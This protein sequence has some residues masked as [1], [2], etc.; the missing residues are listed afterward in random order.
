MTP[1]QTLHTHDAGGDLYVLVFRRT[2]HQNTTK[3]LVHKFSTGEIKTADGR[4][5]V[6][7]ISKGVYE[8]EPDPTGMFTD[9]SFTNQS[10]RVTSDDPN[11]P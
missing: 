1:I 5:N 9:P 7:Y 4:R 6:R 2:T 10:V 3:G 11:A 8:I